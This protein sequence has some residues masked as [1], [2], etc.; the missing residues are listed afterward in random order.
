MDK[1]PI[2]VVVDD[3]RD[4]FHVYLTGRRGSVIP[5]AT[6]D[7]DEARQLRDDLD[8][9]ILRWDRRCRIRRTSA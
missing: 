7:F 6:I 9:L 1:L 3:H 4:L 2:Y 8:A 5:V